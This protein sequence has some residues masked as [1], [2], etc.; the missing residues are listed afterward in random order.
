MQ[1]TIAE[2][3]A[4]R[5]EPSFSADEARGRAMAHKPG[6]FGTLSRLFT[7]P[8]DDEVI[9][10][11][12]GLRY[13]PLWHVKARLHFIYDCRE[14]YRVSPKTHHAKSVTIGSDEYP[15]E[16]GKQ[17]A[18]DI[19]GVE[20]CERDER[21]ELWL[22]AVTNKPVNAQ[23][24][25]KAKIS[26][27]EVEALAAEGARIVEPAVRASGAVRTLLGDDFR[28]VDADHVHEET[29]EVECVDLCLRPMYGY[30]YTWAAKNKTAEIT[31]D[32]VTGEIRTEISESTSPVGKL[33]HPDT[34][35]DLGAETLNLVVPG[36]AIALKVAR[37]IAAKQSGS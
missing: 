11:D 36:G 8:K 18:L 25:A 13:D 37:A 14:T 10:E 22:D 3:G 17:N 7:R 21:K 15:L 26:P 2:Q 34:L 9:V 29:I 20:H 23:P 24:Y 28:P 35:F 1:I 19:K 6:A 33:L 30:K 32:G 12:K 31:I 4:L 16:A 5:F 27:L